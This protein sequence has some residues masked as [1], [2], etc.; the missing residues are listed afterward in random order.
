MIYPKGYL[1]EEASFCKEVSKTFY[2]QDS[3]EWRD[4]HRKAVL[5]KREEFRILWNQTHEDKVLH[6][7]EKC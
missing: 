6:W 2:N 5:D 7:Y 1:Q 3:D 4:T